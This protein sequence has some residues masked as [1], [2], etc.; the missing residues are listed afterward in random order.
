M[1]KS[2]REP[3]TT[4]TSRVFDHIC[5]F[6][7]NK[8]K[9]SQG[10]KS[11]KPLIQS[12]ELRSDEKIRNAAIS[13]MDHRIIAITSLELVA[14]E[15]HN[16]KF[17]YRNYTRE[18][19]QKSTVEPSSDYDIRY[20]IDEQKAYHLLCANIRNT[21]AEPRANYQIN[22]SDRSFGGVQG[23]TWLHQ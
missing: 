18:Q 10:S 14:A 7:E 5:I 9:Y 8:N 13:N 1:R 17:C 11:A 19:K 15:A 21:F 16:N 22:N 3:S 20:Q 12:K 6:Y 23:Y 2:T 4:N